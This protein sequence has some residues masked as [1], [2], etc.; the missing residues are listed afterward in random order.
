ML[1]AC[2][3][4]PAAALTAVL[5]LPV[6]SLCWTVVMGSCVILAGCRPHEFQLSAGEGINEADANAPLFSL[7][8]LKAPGSAAQL[9]E[10]AAPAAEELEVL[11]G[12]SDEEALPAQLRD[13]DAGSDSDEE[14][15]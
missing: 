8:A 2:T 3:G 14:R 15:R 10:S 13:A 4:P 12:D 11:E 1:Q 7:S 6:G 5:S 9:G